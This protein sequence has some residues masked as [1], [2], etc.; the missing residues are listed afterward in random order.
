VSRK[1]DYMVAGTEA[2]TKLAKAEGLGIAVLDEA[3]LLKLLK[4]N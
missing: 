3:G 2:G 1:T 4:G